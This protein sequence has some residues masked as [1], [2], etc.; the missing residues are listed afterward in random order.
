GRRGRSALHL[1]RARMRPPRR[2]RPRHADA[3]RRALGDDL[4]RGLPAPARRRCL[5]GVQLLAFR[6]VGRLWLHREPPGHARTGA[7]RRSFYRAGRGR[8]PRRL[9][10]ACRSRS[11]PPACGP[12]P[13]R[14]LGGDRGGR[15]AQVVLGPR[16]PAGRAGLPPSRLLR[17]RTRANDL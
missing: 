17:G 6:R 14:A 13:P 2:A 9:R 11:D 3:D 15:R 8:R 5:P 1:R 7:G 10:L 12:V 16:T 4:L